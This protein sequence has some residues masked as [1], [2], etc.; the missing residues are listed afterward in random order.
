MWSSS[1]GCGIVKKKGLSTRV[2]S[3]L[4]KEFSGPQQYICE[5]RGG[6]GSGG[7]VCEDRSSHV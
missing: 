4:Y 7:G 2:E 1:S 3:L 6:G 5:A